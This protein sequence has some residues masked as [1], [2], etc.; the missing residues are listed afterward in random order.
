MIPTNAAYVP[1][2]TLAVGVSGAYNGYFVTLVQTLV[3][4]GDANAYLRL[5]WEFDGTW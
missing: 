1:Q 3:A 2:G 4:A 5:G